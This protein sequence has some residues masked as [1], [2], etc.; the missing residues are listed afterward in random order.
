MHAEIDALLT[1]HTWDLVPPSSAYN[2]LGSKWILKS[3]RKVDGTLK[4]HNAKLVAQGFHQQPKLD[5][6]KTF[7][8]VVQH[9]IA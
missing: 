3:K 5:Y 4:Q 9:V 7:S 8:H 1:N 6:T 2:V